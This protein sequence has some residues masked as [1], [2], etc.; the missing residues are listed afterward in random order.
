MNSC[1]TVLAGVGAIVIGFTGTMP[2]ATASG[3]QD[4]CPTDR[5]CLWFNSDFGGARADFMVSDANLSNE[6]FNDGPAY[7]NGW[8]VQVEDNAAS[9]Q[10]RSG[11]QVHFYALRNCDSSGTNRILAAGD[12]GNFSSALKNQISSFRI[13]TEGE[14]VNVDQS[15]A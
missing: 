2:A 8:L 15:N 5:L 3:S 6:L 4:Y 14:C 7:A 10:N 13:Y 11:H 1:R 12:K 9:F